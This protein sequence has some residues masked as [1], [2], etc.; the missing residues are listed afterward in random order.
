MV[1]SLKKK[2]EETIV[3]QKFSEF[4]N[5]FNNW[6]KKNGFEYFKTA[7]DIA[8]STIQRFFLELNYILVGVIR[9]YN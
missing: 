4:F 5:D 8:I 7:N 1:V 6:L 2:G 3:T 9:N